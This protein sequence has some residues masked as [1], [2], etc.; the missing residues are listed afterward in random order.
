MSGR[1]TAPPAERPARASTRRRSAGRPSPIGEEERQRRTA[2]AGGP[3]RRLLGTPG[4]VLRRVPR[5]A[6]AC[7]LIAT[8]SAACWSLLTPPF[9]APDEPSH[10]AYAQY[11]AET[12]R[13]PTSGG[14][15]FSAEE[16]AILRDL[17]QLEVRW[18]PEVQ[19][20]SS[21]AAQQQLREGLVQPLSRVGLGGAGVAASEP[22]LYYALETIPYDLGSGGTLL[23]QLE[24]MRLLSA[25][26]AGLTALFTF[27]F[28]RETLPRVRWAWTVGGLGA[29][30][31]PLLGFTSGVVT[32][33]A[34]LYAVCAAIFYC[35]ARAFGRGLTRSLSVAIGGLIAAG[36]LTKVNFVGLTPGLTL[37][38]VVLGL[39]GV[40]DGRG[41]RR[42][43]RA[44]GSMAIA[45]A[46][47]VSPICAYALRN[48]LEHHPL[49]GI[50]SSAV[51]LTSGR[52]SIL[53]D[54]VYVW[55]L[56]LP[57]LPGMVSYFP[58]LSTIRELWFDRAV[59][60]YGWLD[61][62][63]PVWVYN[64]ALIPAGLIAILGLRALVVSRA[65]LRARLSE[66]LVYLVMSAGLMVLIG[67]DSHLHRLVEG[68]GYAQ[69]RYLM[70]LL[71]LAA[72]MLA[73]AARGAGRRWGP[74]AGAL[75]VLLFLA[76][77]VFSQLLVVSRFYG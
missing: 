55:Q 32:P 19:T 36:F 9:Q 45:M 62:T 1:T 65:A 47:A 51:H 63:F 39:R 30:L 76:Q 58:G 13:L 24:L 6:W 8:L 44:F 75:I 52:E 71:P 70:P 38:L 67:Q 3:A 50:V 61:T 56:Y 40:R 34:M 26:M 73:L 29:A 77:D 33:D 2:R 49:L 15:A 54:V 35:L 12:G 25:L 10:F 42:R 31:A 53:S 23:D 5:A 43:G 41:E 11:L 57:R 16:E 4:R 14:E 48:L 22:P 69:P 27:L 66:L 17:N 68:A 18:H 72:V 28:V 37:G 64:L 21:P 7:A 60:L 46:L 74:A 59:G 20:I